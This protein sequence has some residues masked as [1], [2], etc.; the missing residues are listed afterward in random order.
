MKIMFNR[1]E[2]YLRKVKKDR[3]LEYKFDNFKMLI[4]LY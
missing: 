4:T 3:V 1:A 2:H